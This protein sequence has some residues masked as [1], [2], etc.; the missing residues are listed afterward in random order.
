MD[1]ADL[2]APAAPPPWRGKQ[3]L[4]PRPKVPTPTGKK[5]QRQ[6]AT[7]TKRRRQVA[8]PLKK[9][10]A[11]SSC[12]TVMKRKNK[13][14]MA[15][16][17]TRGRKKVGWPRS[18]RNLEDGAQVCGGKY[19]FRASAFHLQHPH[20]GPPSSSSSGVPLVT[21]SSG[22]PLVTLGTDFSG[23]EAVAS[24]LAAVDIKFVHE[25]ACENHVS[26]C[27]YILYNHAPKMLHLDIRTRCVKNTPAVN[28]YVAGFPCQPFSIAGRNEGEQTENGTLFAHCL[29]YIKHA[30]PR[31]AILENV[32]GLFQRHYE[33]YNTIL[34]NLE[35]LG[36]SVADQDN[37]HYNTAD[38]GL[39]HN[40]PRIFI[41]AIRTNAL[42]HDYVRPEPLP[43]MPLRN[44]LDRKTTD[45]VAGGLPKAGLKRRHVEVAY[46]RAREQG[47]DPAK[48]CL[49]VDHGVGPKRQ[50]SFQVGRSPCLT[51]SR[52]AQGGFWLSTRTRT[53]T[54]AEMAR[55]QGFDADRHCQ[56]C[57]EWWVVRFCGSIC[58]LLN[59]L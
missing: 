51:A 45:N 56:H 38:H 52:S 14:Q 1:F 4:R 16:T 50:A 15:R 18:L 8:C 2:F 59:V 57:A 34:T 44:V 27:K 43:P 35:E 26:C 40:R 55:L 30:L 54:L 7:G 9:T 31:V 12:L 41:V 24:A 47:F 53:M 19:V 10:P 11:A 3:T 32:L 49:V 5:R 36:Y 39:P 37:P 25:F 29:A 58:V 6:V 20:P 23:M 13:K 46:A 21:S 22:V 28:L 17:L 48:V 33:T 42:K